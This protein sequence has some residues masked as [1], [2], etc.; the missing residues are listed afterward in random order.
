M[1]TR[2]NSDPN[3]IEPIPLYS[4]NYA[5][6]I[7]NGSEA[8]VIDPGEAGPIKRFIEQK[9]LRLSAMLVTHH[10][11]DHCGGVA[12]LKNIFGCPVIGAHD[13]RMSFVD[14]GI[15]DGEF[16]TVAGLR[17][18]AIAAPGHTNSHFVYF[19]PDLTA[20]FSGDTLFSAGCGRLFE[21]SAEQMYASLAA[22]VSL[23]DDI[24]V[25]CGHEYTEENLR[26]AE[27]VDPGNIAVKNRIKEV[28]CLRKKGLPSLPVTIAVEKA[29]NPFLRTSDCGIRKWLTLENVPDVEVF[30]ELRRR[31]NRW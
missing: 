1:E 2:E 9:S 17:M 31:K 8:A 12:E 19:F 18:R 11:A 6:V 20:L 10:H 15:H 5:W 7:R 14:D 29:T 23:G 27:M 16:R 4:D 13:A 26:F 30:A 21:G 3:G 25:Y 22:C 24:L 28:Q